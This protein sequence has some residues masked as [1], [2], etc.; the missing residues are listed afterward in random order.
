MTSERATPSSNEVVD[1]IEA[2]AKMARR[3]AIGAGL[4]PSRQA[5]LLD[6]YSDRMQRFD[7]LREVQASG[8]RIWGDDA[9]SPGVKKSVAARADKDLQ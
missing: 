6:Q 9:D 8:Q 7:R 3:A 2:S 5:L 4:N 1:A